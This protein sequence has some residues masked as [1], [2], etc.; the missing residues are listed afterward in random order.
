MERHEIPGLPGWFSETDFKL[1][2]AA[3]DCQMNALNVLPYGQGTDQY[4]I[5][6]LGDSSAYLT[7]TTHEYDPRIRAWKAVP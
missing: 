6:C 1:I 2:E 3:V 5:F 4:L 7:K